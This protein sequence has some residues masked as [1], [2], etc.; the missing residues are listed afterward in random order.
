[1][2]NLKNLN[3]NSAYNKSSDLKNDD[4]TDCNDVYKGRNDGRCQEGS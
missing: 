4:N 2:N 1:M 3:F